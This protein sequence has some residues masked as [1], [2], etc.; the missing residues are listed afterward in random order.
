MPIFQFE[1]DS[2]QIYENGFVE[3]EGSKNFISFKL[4]YPT[5][6][7]VS[8]ETI[9]KVGLRDKS[10]TSFKKKRLTDK[11]LFKQTV[12]G[13]AE[14]SVQITAQMKQSSFLKT[15]KDLVAAGAIAATSLITGGAGLTVLAAASKQAVTSVFDMIKVKDKYV[16]IGEAYI[17]L[18]AHEMPS[19]IELFPKLKKQVILKRKKR[20]KGKVTFT[21]HTLKKNLVNAKIVIS[22]KDLSSMTQSNDHFV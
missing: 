22:I 10:T 16:M 8:L 17:A 5:D 20:S 9:K 14:L 21:K 1:I 18:N 6:G 4:D 12:L 13:D 7:I 15:L 2:I 11:L 3:E 19:K